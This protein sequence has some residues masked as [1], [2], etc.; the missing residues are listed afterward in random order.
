MSSVQ[1]YSYVPNPNLAGSVTFTSGVAAI[2]LVKNS[3]KDN[4]KSDQAHDIRPG[5]A[6]IRPVY[7]KDCNSVHTLNQESNREGQKQGIVR[8]P[9]EAQEEDSCGN[10]SGGDHA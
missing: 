5:T 1:N 2:V 6:F 3:C 4:E 9:P 10:R 8:S 7:L